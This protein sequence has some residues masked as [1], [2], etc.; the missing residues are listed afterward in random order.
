MLP[1]DFL[2]IQ[3]TPGNQLINVAWATAGENGR[4]G[5]YAERS[6]DGSHF[7]AIAWIDANGS[8]TAKQEYQYADK[9]VTTGITYY[10]RIRQQ[11]ES[12]N[13]LYSQTCH[14]MLSGNTTAVFHLSPNPAK[15]NISIA[16]GTAESSGDI[17]ILN[18]QG[19]V[20]R[21]YASAPLATPFALDIS[22]LPAGVYLVSVKTSNDNWTGKFVKE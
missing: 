15:N 4:N 7:T 22:S 9:N 10:Y 17:R 5:Y 11:D 18:A 20:V 13:T 1:L 16:S 14:A 2:Y 21:T 6:T 19:M 8:T 12:G 3:A